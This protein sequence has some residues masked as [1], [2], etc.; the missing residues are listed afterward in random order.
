VSFFFFFF[1]PP[2]PNYPRVG[3]RTRRGH[4][5]TDAALWLMRD[6][7]P[8]PDQAISFPAP[9]FFRDRPGGVKYLGDIFF[10]FL[11][12]FARIKK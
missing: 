5:S 4:F 10:C 3:G 1:L 11:E 7:R 6:R 2:A 12:A 8:K 9:F